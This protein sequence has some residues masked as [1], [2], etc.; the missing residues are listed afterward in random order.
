MD[1]VCTGMVGGEWSVGDEDW[2]L[3]WV[4][5]VFMN[6]V[7]VVIPIY[8]MV[9]AYQF[10]VAG[11]R[12]EDVG[13]AA[14]SP[15]KSPRKTKTTQ[16][17]QPPSSMAR[18]LT[19]THGLSG[20]AYLLVLAAVFFYMIPSAAATTST[21]YNPLPPPP[22]PDNSL[23]ARLQTILIPLLILSAS[24]HSPSSQAPFKLQTKP[25][26]VHAKPIARVDENSSP[27]STSPKRTLRHV[28]S[29]A[30]S[31]LTAMLAGEASAYCT[32]LW[33]CISRFRRPTSLSSILET[34][35][36]R[37]KKRS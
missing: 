35:L 13:A 22:A 32:K 31:I 4:Y 25:C 18:S 11:R 17:S 37:A 24:S 9:D 28:E 29:S 21:V 8:L 16:Q 10:I 7:W 36:R 1:D 12:V 5:L 3:L 15:R 33:R 26:V 23:L 34:T 6:V 19:S 20:S 14:V 2:L 30:S 27:R